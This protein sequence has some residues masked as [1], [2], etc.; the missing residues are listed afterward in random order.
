MP[1]TS[2][3]GYAITGADTSA[4]AFADD[5]GGLVYLTTPSTN[6]GTVTITDTDAGGAGGIVLGKGV[7][8]TI[9]VVCIGP[10]LKLAELT[11]KFSNAADVLNVLVLR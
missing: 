8:V 7:G 9:P 6:V 2:P 11:Y 10:V 5:P 1:Y 3:K 4:H